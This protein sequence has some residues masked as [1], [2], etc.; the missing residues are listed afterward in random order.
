[1]LS[2]LDLV[3]RY[4]AGHHSAIRR[5]HVLLAGD[6]DQRPAFFLQLA[7]RRLETGYLILWLWQSLEVYGLCYTDCVAEN[8]AADSSCMM[9]TIPDRSCSDIV[10]NLSLIVA[11]AWPMQATWTCLGLGVSYRHRCLRAMPRPPWQSLRLACLQ[12]YFKFLCQHIFV[13]WGH[14][15]VVTSSGI[16]KHLFFR[17]PMEAAK[18]LSTHAHHVHNISLY[19][20]H[21]FNLL[22]MSETYV[23]ISLYLF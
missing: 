5:G 6:S 1:M 19:L 22:I 23:N 18:Y 14:L 13:T 2:T 8:N 10:S 9:S 11:F 16:W 12:L 21:I 7:C 4:P 3:R 17:R 20:L 15:Q